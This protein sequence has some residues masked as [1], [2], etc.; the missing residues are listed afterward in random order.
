M[1]VE[2]LEH[3]LPANYPRATREMVQ[4]RIISSGC[5][6]ASIYKNGD[7]WR[8]QVYVAGIRESAS[9][10][11]KFQAEAWSHE[12]ETALKALKRSLTAAHR[13]KED[14]KI[15]MEVCASYSE[16]QIIANSMSVPDTSGVY[17]L[18]RDGA[19]VYVGQS[20]NVYSRVRSHK[21]DKTFDRIAVIECKEKELLH[22][23]KLYIKKFKPILN[24]VGIDRI[25][26]AELVENVL[27]SRGA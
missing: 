13:A 11:E 6:M 25:L 12:R 5:V 18:I 3:A 9:F 21:K 1:C 15:F 16:E 24:V 7:T 14:K 23:E 26:E 8:A 10:E 17:F 22:L 20:N 4:S 2:L 19:I 27:L